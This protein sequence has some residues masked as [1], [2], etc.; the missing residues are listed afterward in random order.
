MSQSKAKAIE[1]IGKMKVNS[2]DQREKEFA[3]GVAL[4]A[5]YES[6]VLGRSFKNI[7][8]LMI[9]TIEAKQTKERARIKAYIEN[10]LESFGQSRD[11][12]LR[13]YGQRKSILDAI[14]PDNIVINFFKSKFK[15]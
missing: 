4:L 15:R 1:A 3:L 14:D 6:P 5:Y 11:V 10:I 13:W 2:S 7:D 12:A 9:D 8:S